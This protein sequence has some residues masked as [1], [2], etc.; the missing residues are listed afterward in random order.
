MRASAI[1]FGT[2]FVAGAGALLV[3]RPATAL[4]LAVLGVAI[5]VWRMRQPPKSVAANASAA[6]ASRVSAAPTA[7]PAA[8]VVPLF[9]PH[10]E[11]IERLRAAGWS[12][13]PAQS[14]TPWLL[15]VN[16][17][18]RLALRPAPRGPRAIGED[19]AEAMGAKAREGAHY[20]AIVCENRPV[21][22][23]TALAKEHRIHIVNLARLEA[24]LALAA[25]FQPGQPQPAATDLVPA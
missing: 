24:Y 16:G 19:I 5:S 18:V 17:A 14:A 12:I 3:W 1:I 11:L 2:T 13:R 22:A 9:Q 25:T 10:A 7:A 20:A 6:P 4:G 8:A 15:V 23:V 21:E